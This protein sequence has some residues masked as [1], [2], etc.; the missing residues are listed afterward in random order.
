MLNGLTG[1]R[2]ILAKPRRLAAQA[3]GKLGLSLAFL[4]VAASAGPA[5]A[6]TANL[7]GKEISVP[8][9]LQ[10]GEELQK[11]IPDLIAFGEKLFSAR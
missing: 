10:D 11:S 8:V 7:I 6:Q 5:L 3:V 1:H 2:A 4:A 9:H